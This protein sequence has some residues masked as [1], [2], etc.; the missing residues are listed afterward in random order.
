MP[1][2]PTVDVIE[3]ILMTDGDL[4]IKDGQEAEKE[5]KD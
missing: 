1:L 3:E 5:K 2:S 4:T